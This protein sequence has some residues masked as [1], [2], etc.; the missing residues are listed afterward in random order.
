LKEDFGK[1]LNFEEVGGGRKF[2]KGEGG[3]LF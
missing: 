3:K 1:E 2:T